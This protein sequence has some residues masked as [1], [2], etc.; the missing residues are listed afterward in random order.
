[1]AGRSLDAVGPD[2]L[3]YGEMIECIRDLML[4]GRPTVRLGLAANAVA[5]PIA[6]AIAGEDPGLVG[7]L[8][9]SLSSDL[10]PRAEQA[11]EPLGVRPRPFSRAVER[12][13]RDWE[14]L[15]PGSVAAR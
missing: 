3:S 7:P 1:V 10:L 6:A 14:E 13:L 5:A 8:M 15:E 2:V 11:A 4:V 9:G 12:A